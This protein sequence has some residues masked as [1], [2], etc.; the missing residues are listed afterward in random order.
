MRQDNQPSLPLQ[1]TP[2]KGSVDFNDF[3][4]FYET[5]N[6]VLVEPGLDT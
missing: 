5:L 1:I 6:Q 2:V 4:N 3:L